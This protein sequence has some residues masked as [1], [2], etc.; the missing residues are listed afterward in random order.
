MSEPLRFPEGFLWGSGTAAHHVE[1]GNDNNQW[2]D[3]EQQPGRIW[4]GDRSG[5]ACG[6]WHSAERDLATAADLGQ[7]AHRLSIEWSRIE[8]RD[9]EFDPAAIARYREILSF[10][11]ER[12]MQP[13]VTLHHFTNP[14]WFEARG[15]W[16]HPDAPQRFNHFVAYAVGALSDLCDMWVTIN[17]PTV[18]AMQGYLLGIWPPGRSDTLAAWRVMAALLRAHAAA[19]ITIH[20]IDP[21]LRVGIAHHIRIMDPARPRSVDVGL[22]A[23]YDQ[24]FNGIFLRAVDTGRL[25][26]PIGVGQAVPGLRGSC[27]FFGCNYYTRDHVTF[28]RRAPAMLF[29]RRFTPDGLPRSDATVTG[30]P[31]GEIYPQGLYRVLKRVSRYRLPI[32]ITE[33][34]VPDDD[35]DQ[36]PAFMLSHLAAVHR[37]IGSGVDVRGVF[38]WSLID[39]FEWSEG[40]ALRFGLIA[41]DE[42]T[43]VRR[44]RRSGALYAA[45]ARANALPADAAGS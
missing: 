18:Y 22:A 1:G 4:H 16:L 19:A 43:G 13:I 17:E 31:Y 30:E 5:D 2:W 32:Y 8:P 20:R 36:R 42:K 29:A 15:G 24:I 41:F 27:D 40:W 21:M 6:W 9:G 39:N 37:A 33:V 28:D 23:V 26:P 3:W 35:D 12:G 34:G 38:W 14:R 44:V 10:I 25:I 7:N 45:I 11:R